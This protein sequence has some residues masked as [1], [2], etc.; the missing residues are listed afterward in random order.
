MSNRQAGGQRATRLV[1]MGFPTADLE[2]GLFG[3]FQW[4]QQLLHKNRA[5]LTNYADDPSV[6]SR[7]VRN[8]DPY[9]IRRVS[10]RP[11]PQELQILNSFKK[12]LQT[13]IACI[14]NS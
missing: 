9:H 1:Q 11:Y 3:T 6:P 10:K 7:Y 8:S 14:A 5:F 2:P 12:V 4:A 13:L